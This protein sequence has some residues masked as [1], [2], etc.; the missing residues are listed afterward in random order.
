LRTEFST[1]TRGPRATH[2]ARG[3]VVAF[4]AA[5]GVAVHAFAQIAIN[6]NGGGD[7]TAYTDA[8]NWIGGVPAN[9]TTTNTASFGTATFTSPALASNRSVAGIVFA[10]S[11]GAFTISGSGG[12][13]L[14]LG[15]SGIDQQDNSTQTLA[16]TLALKLG[17]AD[18]AP[19]VAVIVGGNAASSTATFDLNGNNATIA[20]L[21]LGGATTTSGAAIA[22]GA[23]TLT[24]AGDVSYSSANNPLGATFSGK[25]ALGAANRNFAIDDST[26]AGAD[27]SIS[28]VISSTGGGLIK[29][30]T[31]TLVLS[32]ANTYTGPTPFSRTSSSPC[33]PPPPT[34]TAAATTRPSASSPT[35]ASAT[36]SRARFSWRS[37]IGS[38][39]S[40]RPPC[41]GSNPSSRAFRSATSSTSSSSASTASSARSTKPAATRFCASSAIRR[42]PVPAST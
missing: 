19:N 42:T 17:A 22:T 12:A 35:G 38:A 27:L 31:G 2:I 30:G 37:A 9:D 39:A 1:T 41:S 25:L 11:A 16:A 7:G 24:L 18:A 20:S 29:A 14:S 33:R 4:A 21:S 40:P 34:S 28:A 15:A 26:T 13:I 3:V 23:S 36:P 8:G 5:F 32:G 10:S 6:W